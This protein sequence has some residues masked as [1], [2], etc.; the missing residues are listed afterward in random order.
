MSPFAPFGTFDAKI[1]DSEVD[2]PDLKTQQVTL[3][4][5]AGGHTFE[6]KFLI[7]SSDQAKQERGRQFL[8][9]LAKLTVEGATFN[10]TDKEVEVIGVTLAGDD[11]EFIVIREV[12]GGL[13]I[14]SLNCEVY[15]TKFNSSKTEE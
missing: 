8:A 15:R 5:V 7:E 9:T 1:I 12:E 6:H 2:W 11:L 10:D 3:T 4:I 13:L 14:P